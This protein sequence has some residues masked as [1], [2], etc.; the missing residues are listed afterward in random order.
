MV[1][2]ERSKTVFIAS[3]LMKNI[4][5]FR[6]RFPVKLISCIAFESASS[7]SCLLNLLLSFYNSFKNNYSPA[8]NQLYNHLL[9]ML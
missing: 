7:A 1:P 9:D 5:A 2:Y 3:S 8:N 6:T 4:S